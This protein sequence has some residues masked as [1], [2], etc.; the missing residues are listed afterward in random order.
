MLE[1]KSAIVD[2]CGDIICWCEDLSDEEITE[3]L[4]NH[5]E[6]RRTCIEI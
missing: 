2:E 6:C 4:T 5:I 3:F 1:Y